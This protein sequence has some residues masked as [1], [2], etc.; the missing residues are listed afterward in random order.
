MS[1]HHAPLHDT[2]DKGAYFV[3]AGTLH[4]LPLFGGRVRLSLLHDILLAVADEKGWHLDSWSVF[5]NHYHFVGWGESVGELTRDLHAQ[6]ARL[7]NDDDRTRGRQVWFQYWDTLLTHQ[8]SYYARL[9]YA[10]YNAVHHGL[11]RDAADY[12]WC[13]AATRPRKQVVFNRLQVRDDFEVS[14]S[15][16]EMP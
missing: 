1:W 7:I 3:T 5:P 12:P 14:P 8:R 10:A 16:C 11:V 13:S 15:D 6:T 4:K 2:K 9:Q